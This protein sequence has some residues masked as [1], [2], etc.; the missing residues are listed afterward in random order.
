MKKIVVRRSGRSRK[1]IDYAAQLHVEELIP[2][3]PITK[4]KV[5]ILSIF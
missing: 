5:E 3:E 2:T 1:A 4:K